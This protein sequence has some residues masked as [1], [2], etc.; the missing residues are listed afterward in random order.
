MKVKFI[1]ILF[2][3]HHLTRPKSLWR[4]WLQHSWQHCHKTD[5]VPVPQSWNIHTKLNGQAEEDILKTP[6]LGLQRIL[7]KGVNV[8]HA[9]ELY[10]GVIAWCDDNIGRC[11]FET[12]QHFGRRTVEELVTTSFPMLVLHNSFQMTVQCLLTSM[13]NKMSMCPTWLTV[14]PKAFE[15]A[16]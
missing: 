14:G 11:I 7:W 4:Q 16:G 8:Q 12:F 5:T 2:R 1:I 6:H 15:M 3:R 9:N 10:T 13:N